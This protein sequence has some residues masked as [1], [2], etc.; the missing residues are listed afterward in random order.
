MIQDYTT[1]F[2]MVKHVSKLSKTVKNVSK[3]SKVIKL[4]K[5]VY[6]VL[7][8]CKT[9]QNWHKNFNGPQIFQNDPVRSTFI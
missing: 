1:W 5:T 4:V 2:E 6:Y 8:L 7:I 3:W 9:A